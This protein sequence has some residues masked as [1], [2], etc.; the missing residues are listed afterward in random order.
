MKFWSMFRPTPLAFVAF[1]FSYA[2]QVVTGNEAL[3]LLP[4]LLLFPS[5]L[6]WFLRAVSHPQGRTRRLGI[7]SLD[8]FVSV[9]MAFATA[10]IVA[11]VL[12]GGYGV[13]EAV[14]LLLIYVVSGWVYFYISRAATDRG[15]RAIMAAI[16]VATVFLSIEW[17]HETYTKMVK[18][19]VLE[20]QR[21]SYEYQKRRNNLTDEEMNPSALG[22]QYRAHGLG[23]SHPVT[24]TLVAIGS[25]T[26]LSLLPNSSR[27]MKVVLLGLSFAV[28]LIGF[29]TT[30]LVGYLIV[31]PIVLW[32]TSTE[33]TLSDV[34][35]RIFLYTAAAFVLLPA[36]SLTTEAG[37]NLLR[38]TM[39]LIRIQF[40]YVLG[41]SDDMSAFYPVYKNAFALY[42]EFLQAKPLSILIGEG[43]VGYG[44]A[45]FGRGG[46][47]GLL[48]LAAGF[49][50]PFTI[51]FFAAC[52]WAVVLGIRTVKY[53][54]GQLDQS[55]ILDIVFGCATVTF[56][57]FSFVHYGVIF[58][59]AVIVLFYLAL[60]L[61]SR[62][63]ARMRVRNTLT[64]ARPALARELVPLRAAR[65]H[66]PA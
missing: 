17:V 34:V 25:F 32:L 45:T 39:T 13:V 46:D 4:Y 18:K 19:E 24:G 51:Y 27:R 65:G 56:L 20:F 30:A 47:I 53:H 40:Q 59:K 29:A 50:I 52:T 61:I 2:L 9:F 16:A 22:A 28:L 49:G 62:Y 11:G 37:R 38:N 66:T 3:G 14:R 60:G 15:I 5:F 55:Q 44:N 43:P 8:L 21:Q 7:G 1:F 57:L 31:L 36:L 26:T 41:L 63:A 42:V 12:L 35:R 64:W 48:D 6:I 33:T 58:N 54:R 10:H 23:G